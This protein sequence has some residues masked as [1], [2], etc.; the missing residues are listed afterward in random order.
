MDITYI[1]KNLVASY[2]VEL[3]VLLEYLIKICYIAVDVHF[4]AFVTVVSVEVHILQAHIH[5][6]DITIFFNSSMTLV[7]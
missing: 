4:K 1:S 5:I 2:S 3:I 6:Q 7:R